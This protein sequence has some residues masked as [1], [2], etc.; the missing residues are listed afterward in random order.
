MG[1][2]H[3][4]TL[5]IP[6]DEILCKGSD[7]DTLKDIFTHQ[8]LSEL[9]LLRKEI[10]NVKK[11]NIRYSLLLAFVNTITICNSTFQD[12]PKGRGGGCIMITIKRHKNTTSKKEKKSKATI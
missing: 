12:T 1:G 2:G 9:A 11:E 5:W 10:L 6:K 4:K 3:N 7:V 8:Q